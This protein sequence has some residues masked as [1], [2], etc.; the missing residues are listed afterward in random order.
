MPLT[1]DWPYLPKGK[2]YSEGVRVLTWLV[3][4]SFDIDFSELASVAQPPV[5]GSVLLHEK[6]RESFPDLISCRIMIC[7]VL[8]EC[9]GCWMDPPLL[10]HTFTFRMGEVTQME[11]KL[12]TN[13]S[14]ICNTLPVGTIKLL[15]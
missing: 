12:I 8:T 3:A 11:H 13:Y 2:S 6:L 7:G 4:Y 10:Q 14:H 15:K 1:V 9:L 5:G